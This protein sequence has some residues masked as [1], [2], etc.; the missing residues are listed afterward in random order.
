MDL[1]FHLAMSYR[2]LKHPT[3]RKNFAA[4]VGE[5]HALILTQCLKLFSKLG[6]LCCSGTYYVALALRGLLC[7]KYI[8]KKKLKWFS[9]KISIV[10][11]SIL[12]ILKTVT[13]KIFK[14]L[15]YVRAG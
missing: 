8:T 5:N 4:V 12:D 2:D 7:N 15:F 13:E 14:R 6:Y 1:G 10:K 9:E 11:N 3:S